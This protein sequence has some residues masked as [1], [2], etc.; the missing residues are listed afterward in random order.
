M[1]AKLVNKSLNDKSYHFMNDVDMDIIKDI[2]K[3][4]GFTYKDLKVI[5][6]NWILKFMRENIE[7]TFTFTLDNDTASFRHQLSWD[8]GYQP[9]KWVADNNPDDLY[10]ALRKRLKKL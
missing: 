7:F 6:Q 5:Y 1:R 4:Y 9:E 8:S 2:L 10:N 3:E